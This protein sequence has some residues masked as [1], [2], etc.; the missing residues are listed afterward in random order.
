MVS[1]ST[2]LR[3]HIGKESDLT[4]EQVQSFIRAFRFVVGKE[5][6]EHKKI[7]VF[8]LGTFFNVEKL[9]LFEPSQTM[10]NELKQQPA[11]AKTPAKQPAGKIPGKQ[12][13]VAKQPAGKTPG[14]QPATAKQPAGKTPGKQPATAK[15]PAGKTPGKQPATA[16]QPAG[17]TPGKQPATAKQP[18]GKTPGKQPATAKQPAG[19]TPG[20]QPA[21]AKQPAG[22]TPGKQPAT[23]KQPAGKTPGKQPATAKQPAGKTPGK[24]PNSYDKTAKNILSKQGESLSKLQRVEP[25]DL[26]EFQIKSNEPKKASNPVNEESTT[27]ERPEKNNCSKTPNLGHRRKLLIIKKLDNY[28]YG[29]KP[30]LESRFQPWGNE[31]IDWELSKLSNV[32]FI[33]GDIDSCNKER[34]IRGIP[35]IRYQNFYSIPFSS[36][37]SIH[38][39]VY[40]K[41][42]IRVSDLKNIIENRFAPGF[43]KIDWQ[44]AKK[45]GFNFI[46][47][48]QEDIE[49]EWEDINRRRKW[50]SDNRSGVGLEDTDP[51]VK[52]PSWEPNVSLVPLKK[53]TNPYSRIKN[54]SKELAKYFKSRKEFL[55]SWA[56]SF[57]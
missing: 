24:Q 4:T 20:K 44:L 2:K 22:K 12:P 50:E 25:R 32:E 35:K 26:P 23:A 41:D 39:C 51:I 18:A 16:K 28:F 1:K 53:E 56:K 52:F 31:I 21:T 29:L 17:K 38:G 48:Y 14:K 15:Q 55:L 5:L 45:L 3:R 40:V 57:R 36:N 13:A 7:R 37:E 47:G 34:L 10:V 9:I 11:I 42:I 6:V 49:K 43:V 8:R 30:L 46:A 19:K 33:A 54:A 27:A